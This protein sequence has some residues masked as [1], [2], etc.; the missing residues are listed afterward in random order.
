MGETLLE[1]KKHLGAKG[2]IST[3][4]AIHEHSRSSIIAIEK[5]IAQLSETPSYNRSEFYDLVS[6]ELEIPEEDRCKEI[7]SN[8]SLW[9]EAFLQIL[10]GDWTLRQSPTTAK[11]YSITLISF[12][13]KLLSASPG[14]L[15]DLVPLL[16]LA[17]TAKAELFYSCG[18]WVGLGDAPEKE[19]QARARKRI[20]VKKSKVNQK[21]VWAI[22]IIERLYSEGAFEECKTLT[23]AAQI[24]HDAMFIEIEEGKK[25][26]KSKEKEGEKH[27]WSIDSIKRIFSEVYGITTKNYKQP[28][29]LLRKL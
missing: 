23:K 6:G 13:S 8:D 15:H 2:C 25:V 26:G 22:S 1:T 18:L 10:R 11:S 12:Y 21:W 27:R 17:D 29:K 14:T 3:E 28:L 19:A 4:S 24:T 20:G 7:L 9:R 16:L 5:T